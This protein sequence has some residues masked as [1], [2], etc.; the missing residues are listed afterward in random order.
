GRVRRD[1][2]SSDK[3]LSRIGVVPGT[4]SVALLSESVSPSGKL[5]ERVRVVVPAV[6]ESVAEPV[7]VMVPWKIVLPPSV[8]WVVVRSPPTLTEAP[9]AVRNPSYVP[10][11][12]GVGLT[13]ENGA[14]PAPPTRTSRFVCAEDL[15]TTA[16][17]PPLEPPART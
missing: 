10:P 13:S 15:A 11:G 5:H 6:M 7:S 14:A 12:I 17:W 2:P 1:P 9:P 16:P 4:T 8:S 3:V